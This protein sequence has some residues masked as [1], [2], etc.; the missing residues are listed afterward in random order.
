MSRI[1]RIAVLFCVA[2]IGLI[3]IS[4]AQ[5]LKI[6]PLG[7]S[8][9]YDDNAND[10]TNPRPV[11]DRIAYRYRLYQLLK[12]AH[13][14]F[15]FIGSENSGINY[16]QD[17]EYD[18]NAGFPGINKSQLSY[19][20]DHGYN[21]RY[22]VWVTDGPYLTFYH[23]DIILLEI[24][25]N[26]L[27]TDPAPVGDILDDIRYY[28]PNCIVLVARIINRAIYSSETTTYND[29]VQAL[30]AARHDPKIYMVN[31]ETGAGFIYSTAPGGDMNDLLHPNVSGYNK[32][33]AKWFQALDAL[34]QAPVVAD[35]P[36]QY[37]Y[38]DSEFPL[39]DLYD[40]V[41][42]AEDSVQ[43][44]QWSF[45]LQANTHLSASVETGH[46][47][48]VQPVT[49]NWYGSETIR[50]YAKDRG[51]GGFPKTDSTDVIF[52]VHPANDAPVITSEP[53]DTAIQDHFYA[54][55]VI[56]NDI[57]T[58]DVVTFFVTQKPNWLTFDQYT[59]ILSGTPLNANVG[60]NY[61]TI[62]ASDGKA[63]VDQSFVLQVKN[64]N[65]PPVFTS[66]P[67]T[68]VEVNHSYLYLVT[69][70]DVDVGDVVTFEPPV[71]PSWLNFIP[72][73][74]NAYLVNTPTIQ[75]TGTFH[76]T[77]KATDG[78]A[79]ALQSFTVTVSNHSALP[80]YGNTEGYR[81]FPNPAHEKL[82][83][84]FENDNHATLDLYD[85]AGEFKHQW[86]NENGNE[87]EADISALPAGIYIYKIDYNGKTSYG[88]ISKY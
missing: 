65:D 32:M 82:T 30:V 24:G 29:N 57:D 56:A 39:V 3:Q 15:D 13:V 61:V 28:D 45:K 9:T 26:D 17:P 75:D 81:L 42:D 66:E 62:R 44:I 80:Q 20:L 78:K 71:I 22:S 41:T 58:G 34:N 54:Y 6:M 76:I 60:L 27:T 21:Q 19:L 48:K 73:V 1:F 46:I 53:P 43:Y 8:I 59:G 74:S 88:K 38:E 18:D 77:L 12:A 40:Y 37:T 7:N 4:Y 63:Y 85:L 87:I 55:Q 2:G 84:V 49:P 47:L 79:E 52:T 11:G 31:M 35:F 25:T 5:T 67:I 36:E 72:G 51:N 83:V 86:Q 69:V 33:A 14:D 68:E 64:V 16:F 70:S 10:V 50:L 23:P